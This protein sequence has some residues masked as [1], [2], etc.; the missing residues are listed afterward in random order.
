MT[1]NEYQKLSRE[2]AIY[3]DMGKN[4]I[5][6]TLGLCGEAGEIAEKIKKIIRDKGGIISIEDTCELQKE[7]G[8]VLWYISNLATELGVSLKAIAEMNIEKLQS[9]K[10]R[11][12]INWD[13]DNR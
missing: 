6:L 3:P 5:Y 9:R 7:L 12:V 13:G 1:F 11:G 4:Y 2:T 8:D 10:N